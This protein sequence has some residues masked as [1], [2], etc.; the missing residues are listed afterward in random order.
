MGGGTPALLYGLS[1]LGKKTVHADDF[2]GAETAQIAFH[3]AAHLGVQIG[4]VLFLLILR[5]KHAAGAHA[6]LVA[7]AL[8]HQPR[9]QLGQLHIAAAV[10][11]HALGHGRAEVVQKPV[12]R[13]MSPSG[14]LQ[15]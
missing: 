13:H 8:Q 1:F 14:V 6:F 12:F 5:V 2:S 3:P 15:Q 4:Q 7:E 9:F 10:A 11:H